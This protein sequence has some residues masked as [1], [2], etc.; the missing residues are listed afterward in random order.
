MGKTVR[1]SAASDSKATI[2]AHHSSRLDRNPKEEAESSRNDRTRVPELVDESNREGDRGNE[3]V[4]QD[5]PLAGVDRFE[6]LTDLE[7]EP[8]N[9]CHYTEAKVEARLIPRDVFD[10][11]LPL[12]ISWDPKIAG[13][14]TQSTEDSVLE[15]LNSCGLGDSEITF[16]I[17]DPD[18]RSWNPP[19]RHILRSAI[20]GFPSHHC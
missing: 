11:D 13:I 3:I 14:P 15:M 5:D 2:S 9:R 1:A 20:F 19:T 17:P 8:F 6:V 4:H 18:D 16:V 7:E 10:F 12:A